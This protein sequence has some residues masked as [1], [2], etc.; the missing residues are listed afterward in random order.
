MI[1]N[2]I[3]VML[4]DDHC[5]IRQ[6]LCALLAADSDIMVI[7]EVGSGEALLQEIEKGVR[8]DV[9]LMD[10]NMQGISGIEATKLLRERLPGVHVIG[11]TATDE[12]DTILAML[13]AGACSYVIKSMA[14]NELVSAIKGAYSRKPTMP[15]EIQHKLQQSLR[16]TF[17]L[18]N[19]YHPIALLPG[20]TRREKDVIQTLMEGYSNKEIARHLFISERTVQTHLS[21]IFTKMN[22][23][24]RTEAV[25]V[26]MRDG[27]LF[28]QTA[29]NQM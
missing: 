10:I 24:S 14:A 21:N 18:H 23:T 17:P 28:R 7:G 13:Q 2:K 16:R 6:G 3:C 5:M 22:V 29:A 1:K 20:L 27:W 26:A 12:D 11:L 25:L 9:V 15:T 8:P 19:S 4:V